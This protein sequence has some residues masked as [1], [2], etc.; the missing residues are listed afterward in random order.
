MTSRRSA[1]V[2][3]P[4][5]PSR[6]SDFEE[7]FGPRG[8]CGGCWCMYWRLRSADF[9]KSKGR[10]NKLSIKALVDGRKVP[11]LLAYRDGT[12]VGWVCVAPREDFIRF[13]RSRLFQPLDDLPVW[14][15]VCLFVA[16][17]YRNSGVSVKLIKSAVDY[18]RSK[19]G[20]IVEAYPVR[21]KKDPMPDVFAYTGL[22]SAYLKADFK[23]C[24]WR[25]DTRPVMRRHLRASRR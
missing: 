23:V 21:P 3:K 18:V 22:Y 24:E 8:A 15:I 20:K 16:K 19:G 14:S 1:L 5:T 10:G 12:A 9:E 17:P 13:E 2:C 6:W 25:S 4:L 11:G 7:L